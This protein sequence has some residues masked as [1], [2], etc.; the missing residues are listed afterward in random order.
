MPN[1]IDPE[2]VERAKALREALHHHNYRYYVLD[3]PEVSDAAYDRMMAELKEL[4]DRH[5]EIVTDDSPTRRVGAAPL[6]KFESVAHAVPMLS[7]DNGFKEE[8]IYDFDRRVRRLLGTEDMVRYTAEPKMDGVAVELV[9]ENGILKTASTRGDGATGELI[10]PNVRTIRTVP[11]FLHTGGGPI[12]SLLE[13]R[14]E[15]FIGHS[16]FQKLN[17]DRRERELQPFANPRN[18]AAGSLRQL[19]SRVT[20]ERPLEIYFYGVGRARGMSPE[21]HGDLLRTLQSLGLRTNPL[22][23]SDITIEEAVQYYRELAEMRHRI[24]YDIDG[25]V[26]KVDSVEAQQRLGATSRSPR[27]VIAYKFSAV[28]ETTGLLDI[29]VQV[30]RTGALTPVAVLDPVNIGGV[31]V[32]RATLHNEDEIRRKDIRIGDRVLVQR[33]GDVIPEV[34]KAIE[35]V[36]TGREAAF[37]FP[38]HCPACGSR[39]VRMEGEAVARCMNSR[40]SAQLKERIRHFGS[41]AAFD[42]DGLGE[43]LIDQLVE[44]GLVKTYADLFLL[45]SQDLS[46]LERM[47]AKSA[48]NLVDAVEA[49]KRVSF[50]RFVYALGIRHVGEHVAS[51]LAGRFSSLDELMAAGKEELAAIEGVGPVIAASISEFFSRYENRETVGQLKMAGVKITYPKRE[52]D[53]SLSGKTFVLTGTL[54]GMT[55]EEAKDR[56]E[57]AGGKVTGSVSGKTDY[58]V[59]G[60]DP[61]SKLARARSLGVTVLDQDGLEALFDREKPPSF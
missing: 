30:G 53:G 1:D 12:P 22:V 34:V 4:E 35:S 51:I 39:A 29:E 16:G 44:K 47:G 6:D 3:D 5:P 21:T 57:A 2:V 40:C 60:E 49:G 55:R 28:Q 25:E 42:I 36:R 41:K 56:I 61:G 45:D 27:W 26:I 31:T 10:T 50:E 23:R 20:A 58:L 11:F 7:I 17:Q 59:V 8:D 43:K 48:E 14:G 46:G 37:E 15:V 24:E 18:A 33:A 54:D 52:S 13:V 38:T 19:D 9:Y 32:K